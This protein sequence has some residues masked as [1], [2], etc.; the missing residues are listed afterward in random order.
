[1]LLLGAQ[2]EFLQSI[3]RQYKSSCEKAEILQACCCIQML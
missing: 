3:I 1:M 2:F